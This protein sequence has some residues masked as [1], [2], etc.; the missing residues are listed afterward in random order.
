MMADDL[1]HSI[2]M[3]SRFSM[4]IH[5]FV[6]T[7]SALALSQIKDTFCSIIMRVIRQIMEGK[8]QFAIFNC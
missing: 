3:I 6:H 2:I 7:K 1:D 4:C 5:P 8:Q